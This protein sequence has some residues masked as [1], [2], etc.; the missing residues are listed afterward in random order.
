M[1]SLTRYVD[2]DMREY[3]VGTEEYVVGTEAYK[4]ALT[5]KLCNHNS[6]GRVRKAPTR[7]ADQTIAGSCD[8]VDKRPRGA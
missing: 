4:A 2:V 3:V 1:L 8:R 7:F 5:A 6:K